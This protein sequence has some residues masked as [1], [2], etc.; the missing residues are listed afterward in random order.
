MTERFKAQEFDEEIRL[1]EIWDEAHK[2][3]LGRDS[4]QAKLEDAAALAQVKTFLKE[5]DITTKAGADKL[6]SLANE[7]AGKQRLLS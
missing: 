1:R 6:E 4:K 7:H 5:N 3:R 2:D